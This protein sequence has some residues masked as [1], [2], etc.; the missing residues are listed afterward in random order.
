M[1]DFSIF[2]EKIP[3]KK[4]RLISV[5]LNYLDDNVFELRSSL[6]HFP[7]KAEEKEV[8]RLLM[9]CRAFDSDSMP[10][11]SRSLTYR[12]MVKRAVN[13]G[14]YKVFIWQSKHPESHEHVE[15]LLIG[16]N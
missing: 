5:D 12:D 8:K 3:V 9:K 7:F 10:N 6:G 1:S 14:T 2:P 16:E 15:K 11:S 4:N 13:E